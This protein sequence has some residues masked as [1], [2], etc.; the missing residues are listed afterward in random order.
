[1]T[2]GSHI[3]TYAGL[4]IRE[5]DPQATAPGEPGAFAWRIAS[6]YD[7]GSEYFDEAFQALATAPWSGMVQAL[8]LGEWGE[9]YEQSAP[10]SQLVDAAGA[11]SGLTALFVGEMTYE[12][13]EISW[14][15]QDD[16][17]PIFGAYPRLRVLTIRGAEGLELQP[18][19]HDALRELTFESGGLPSDVVRAVGECDFP[20]LEKLELWL[21]TDNYG[22]DATVDDLAQILAGSRLPSLR[23]LGL[24]DAEIADLVAA[25]VASAPVVARL[26]TLDLSMGMLS[27]TGAVALLAGQPLTHL[28]SLNLRH[29][30]ISPPVMARIEE[31]LTASG[32][33]VDLSDAGDPSNEDRRYIEVSE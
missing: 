33:T 28:K 5:F 26:S 7:R 9:A 14:I 16:V 19:R 4:P 25:A 3:T 2:I 27:D 6:D 22:G 8:V 13:Q 11:L 18:V 24:M 31:E 29:H 1:M 21:G 15:Q 23:H 17:T 12:E 20:A 30:F 32:V 10:V